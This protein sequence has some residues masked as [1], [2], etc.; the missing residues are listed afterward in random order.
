MITYYHQLNPVLIPITENIGIRWYSLAYIAGAL[1]AYFAGAYLIRKGRLSLPLPQLT[2][3]IFAGALGAV[4]GGRLGYCLFYGPELF[5]S[6]DSSFPFWGPLKIHQGGMS[7]HGGI[8]GLLVFQIFYA[9]RHK[10]SFFATMDLAAIAGFMGIFLGRIANFINGELYGRVIEGKAFLGVRFPSELYLWASQPSLYKEQLLSLKALLPSLDSIVQTSFKIP[11]EWIWREWV[12]KAVEGDSVF[13]SY[14]SYINSLIIANASHPEIKNLLEPLLS[15]RHP[16][17]FYQ[18]LLGG[19]LPF[20]IACVLCLKPKKAGLVSL[21]SAGSYFLFRIVTEF[22]REPDPQIGFQ[23]FHL[24]RGQWL[25]AL[26]FCILVAY[27][28]FIYRQEPKGFNR[29]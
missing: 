5:L 23:L 10:L 3:I 17:Q 26:L 15:L 24:T 4:V 11:G 12:L 29:L 16:S 9:Y 1:F 27:G 19:L 28:Y 22:Y 18:A 8:L 13:E 25:S 6:F 21:I 20:L 2:D 7:S 14:V